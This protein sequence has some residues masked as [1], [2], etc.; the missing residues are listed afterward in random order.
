MTLQVAAT[1]ERVAKAIEATFLSHLTQRIGT[2]TEVTRPAECSVHRY[3]VWEAWWGL[4]QTESCSVFVHTSTRHLL[5]DPAT[6]KT[7]AGGPDLNVGFALRSHRDRVE[8]NARLAT[9]MAEALW[10][11][12]AELGYNPHFHNFTS[13]GKPDSTDWGIAGTILFGMVDGAPGERW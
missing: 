1:V 5:V 6:G 13:F 11:V 4:A 10:D 2:D 8:V 3:V 9:Y 7:T 12:A